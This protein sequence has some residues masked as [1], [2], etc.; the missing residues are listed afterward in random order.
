MRTAQLLLLAS[1]LTLA[2]FQDKPA[3]PAR[4][5][6][7][8]TLK[9][10]VLAR[11]KEGGEQPKVSYKTEGRTVSAKALSATE[12]G[13][14]LSADGKP[15]SASWEEFGDGGL[16]EL[17]RAL[18]GKADPEITVACLLLGV[19]LKQTES[20]EFQTL[21]SDLW[22]KNVE[23]ALKVADAIEASKSQKSGAWFAPVVDG[24]GA[25]NPSAYRREAY[26][27]DLATMYRR[28]GPDYAYYHKDLS[29]DPSEKF[30]TI[31]KPEDK[32]LKFEGHPSWTFQVGDRKTYETDGNAETDA[33]ALYVPEKG[34]DPGIDRIK[35][36]IFVRDLK[37][38]FSFALKPYVAFHPEPAAGDQRWK[39]AA[40]GRIGAPIATAR[41]RVPQKICSIT[42]F[43]SGLVGAMGTGT[44]GYSN[45]CMM[46]PRNKVPTGVAVTN[47][48]EFA[49]VTV[50]DTAA[51]K[52]QVAV[53]ALDSCAEAKGGNPLEAWWQSCPGMPS[54]GIVSGMKLLGFVDLPGMS[55]PTDIVAAGNKTGSDTHWEG[56]FLHLGKLE[57]SKQAVRDSFVKGDNR[58]VGSTAGFAVVISKYEKKV[59][60]LDLK[61]L[62]QYFREMYLTSP[63]NF[64]KTRK[65]GPGPKDW[66]YTFEVEPRCKPRLV[67]MLPL[68]AAPT[69]LLAS[70]SGGSAKARAFVATV[71][72]KV[73][74]YS[75]GNLAE[76]ASRSSPELRCVGVVPVGR[77]PCSISHVIWD[78]DYRLDEFITCCRGDRE[79]CF[80]KLDASLNSGKV[81]RRL[82]DS[83]LQDPV[84]VEN[85]ITGF[86][87]C[88]IVT[89]C[90]FKG[91]QI[92]N[93]RYG[94][95]HTPDYQKPVFTFGVGPDGK[96]EIECD[97]WVECPGYPFRLTSSNV[98]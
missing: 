71:D 51:I 38:N 72:G 78:G 57:L 36:W 2:G 97:G 45:P 24:S 47:G 86:I 63:E 4:D 17:A 50:W 96:S 61:P 74:I 37:G 66:P 82:R 79:L 32:T 98:P 34:G 52:G 30:P 40:G 33:Q 3:P 5:E 65:L 18:L 77:N 1:S 35:T 75:V 44:S 42:V 54:L 59:A 64:A 25:V 13:L 76:E 39:A 95:I 60:F 27:G 41:A 58:D 70:P 92:L 91:R 20:K 56:K 14:Q 73:F 80:V 94:P 69:A 23:G 88:F 21:L 90:D 15:L 67:Q 84:D 55:A 48:N 83:R 31:W 68:H 11:L 28:L 6:V 19:R 85:S 12:E 7:R 43:T 8:E 16:Y 81:W 93:Y 26:A 87:P 9:S 10:F 89:V 22:A 49:L 62:F 46:L 29:K 53:I